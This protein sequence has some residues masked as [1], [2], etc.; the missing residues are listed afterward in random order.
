[1]LFVFKLNMKKRH[2][3]LVYALTGIYNSLQ[4]NRTIKKRI[5]I[6]LNQTYVWIGS[7]KIISVNEK[8]AKRKANKRW[9]SH[10]FSIKYTFTWTGLKNSLALISLHASIFFFRLDIDS[11]S[12][13][14]SARASNNTSNLFK[15]KTYDYFKLSN[16]NTT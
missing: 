1:M 6:L 9:R 3:V 4:F 15:L 7:T 11:L 14:H 8:W 12:L 16:T 2:R 5:V 10:K 13:T